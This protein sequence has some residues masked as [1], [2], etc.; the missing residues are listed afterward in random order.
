[1]LEA[2]LKA[3]AAK[4]HNMWRQSILHDVTKRS[5]VINQCLQL[6]SLSDPKH[7]YLASFNGH[8]NS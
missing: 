3:L 8:N 2:S 6:R 5:A 1:M 4:L 7:A